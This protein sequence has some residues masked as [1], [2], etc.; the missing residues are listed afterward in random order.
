LRA[1][2]V[3]RITGQ[4]DTQ[5]EPCGE[6]QALM[7]LAPSSLAQLP[8]SGSRDLNFIGQLIRRS[9]CYRMNVGTDISRIPLAIS[10]LLDQLNP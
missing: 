6:G 5:I 7:A 9:P 3:P 8:T 4:P 1:I 2:L 10:R